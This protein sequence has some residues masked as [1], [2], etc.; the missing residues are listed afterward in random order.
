MTDPIQVQ[1]AFHK[2]YYDLFYYQ[3]PHK[4]HLCMD[5]IRSG[6]I[7]NH[8]H[9]ELL[10][11]SFSTE[12]I[13]NAL[14]SIPNDKALGL[15]GYNSRFFKVAW[16]IAGKDVVT[17]VQDFCATGKL[18]KSWNITS[19]TLVLKVP[20]L[21]TPSDFRPKS[22]CHVLYK[23][24]SKLI[25]SKLKSV[26]SFLINQVEGAFVTK[27]SILHNVLYARM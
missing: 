10:N 5:I 27:R 9:W 2:F 22:C 21:V 23:C 13:K 1:H 6:P 26:L 19:V 15:D 14:W 12:E 8:D 7:L 16:S 25:W 20:C 3:L 17:S 11:L 18:L 24:I 4:K